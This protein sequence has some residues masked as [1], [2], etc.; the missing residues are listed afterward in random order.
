MSKKNPETTLEIIIALSEARDRMVESLGRLHKMQGKTEEGE[1]KCKSV[2]FKTGYGAAMHSYGSDPDFN[3]L[4]VDTAIQWYT[5]RIEIVNGVLTAVDTSI[6]K[7]VG[8][9]LL[10]V[11]RS[12]QAVN[13]D[14]G[15]AWTVE[16]PEDE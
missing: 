12:T 5:N 14:T 4:M 7:D 16:D 10:E 11:L 15:L 3:V 13:P 1:A 2:E 6:H 8:Q 9:S